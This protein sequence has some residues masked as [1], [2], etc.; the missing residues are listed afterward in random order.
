MAASELILQELSYYTIQILVDN[1]IQICMHWQLNL[2]AIY[3]RMLVVL[4]LAIVG[5][6]VLS[7][8]PKLVVLYSIVLAVLATKCLVFFSEALT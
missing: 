8:L 7:N 5:Q 1:K 6:K 2:I 4:Y 3:W